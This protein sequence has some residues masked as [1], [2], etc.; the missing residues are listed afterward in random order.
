MHTIMLAEDDPAMRE[1]LHVVLAQ[2]ENLN[3]AAMPSGAELLRTASSVLPDLVL[4]DLTMS[5]I[6]G[7]ET[8]RVL[9]G[10][11]ETRSVPILFVTANPYRLAGIE[12][13]GPCDTL[14]KPFELPEFVS[15]V[16]ALLT[17]S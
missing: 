1:L 12:L 16:R 6:D 13:Q 11:E 2:E 17:A 15:R 10:Q 3:V 5:G 9:R 14:V 8:Y 4:L 7:L